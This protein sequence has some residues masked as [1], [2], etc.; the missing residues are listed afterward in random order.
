MGLKKRLTLFSV[1][2]LCYFCVFSQDIKTIILKDTITYSEENTQKIIEF[3][4]FIDASIHNNEPELFLSKLD[5][6]VFF[7]RIL[8]LIPSVDP[9]DEYVKSFVSGMKKGLNKFPNEIIAEVENGSYYDFISYRYD[10][11]LQTYF[12]LFRL[13]SS[14]SGMNYHDFRI[15]KKDGEM[16]FSDMYLYISGE[17]LT[18]TLARV[19][20]YTM[21]DKKLFGLIKTPMDEGIS[22][23]IKA[24]TYN[25]TGDFKKAYKLM[26]GITSPLSKEKFFLIFKSLVASNV[27]DDKY[28]KSLEDLIN[29]FSD[30]PTIGLNKVDYHI[31]K[32]NYYEAIQVINQLQNE[33]EDDFLNYMK[34]NVAFQDEN[35]DLALNYYKYTI[36]NYTGFFEGQAGYLNTLV[37]MKKNSEAV[38]YLDTLIADS[39][40]KPSLIDYIEEDDEFGEN[41]LEDLVKS[42]EYKIWKRKKK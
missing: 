39:Y 21:P 2:F 14:E 16:Q 40:E 18:E 7:K 13:Y 28:L 15:H 6:D 4:E 30:D 17:N 32:G 38:D 26:N 1:C 10:Q 19:M 5:K 35:Y 22:D 31:Y 9:Q 33:T 42:K 24:M 25:N 34:A 41:I 8:D 23:L 20:T 27:D 12:A 36:E 3:G 11:T 37:M 29:T